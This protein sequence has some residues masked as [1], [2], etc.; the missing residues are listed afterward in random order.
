LFCFDRAGCEKVLEFLLETLG[1]A[2][3]NWKQTSP[4]WKRKI[5]A[6]EAWQARAKAR[7]RQADR[8]SKHKREDDPGLPDEQKTSWQSSFDPDEPIEQFSFANK[9]AYSKMELKN[10]ISD[11]SG[12]VQPWIL[13]ALKRGIGVHHAGMNKGYRALVERRA[14]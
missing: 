7:E 10:D 14:L 8:E 5:Q 6:W 12:S 13:R 2:E 4:E 1:A 9:R 11:L 3:N